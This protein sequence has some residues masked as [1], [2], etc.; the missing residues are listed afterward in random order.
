MLWQLST[1]GSF[2]SLDLKSLRCGIPRGVPGTGRATRD[3]GMAKAIFS[4]LES[5]VVLPP[6]GVCYAG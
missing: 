6:P 1:L 5:G 3:A 2:L 4:L